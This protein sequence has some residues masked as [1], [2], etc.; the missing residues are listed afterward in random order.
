M[1]SRH[2]AKADVSARETATSGQLAEKPGIFQRLV[3]C[4]ICFLLTAFPISAKQG[5]SDTPSA[6]V[7]SMG[8]I[9][10]TSFCKVWAF[11]VR[12]NSENCHVLCATPA[13]R[14]L[15]S[16]LFFPIKPVANS[17]YQRF[18]LRTVFKGVFSR[19]LFTPIKGVVYLLRSQGMG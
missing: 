14:P 4:F 5:A 15:P 18:R 11:G 12:S 10:D 9:P 2:S 13:F 7:S 16:P 19:L 3:N 8:D 6:S 17:C 1:S